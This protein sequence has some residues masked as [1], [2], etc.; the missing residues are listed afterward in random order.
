MGEEGES[1][2]ESER[3]RVCVCVCVCVCVREGQGG[4]IGWP[5][6][7]ERKRRPPSMGQKRDA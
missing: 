7:K 6:G 1:K 5:M 3:E 2:I 4:H